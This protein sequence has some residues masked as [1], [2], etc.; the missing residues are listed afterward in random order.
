MGKDNAI[1]KP[2]H[3]VYAAYLM[4]VH[5][6]NCSLF[7]TAQGD[8]GHFWPTRGLFMLMH[9]PQRGLR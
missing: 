3:V 1:R 4:R 7:T 6:D 9:F 5:F 8:V 2:A